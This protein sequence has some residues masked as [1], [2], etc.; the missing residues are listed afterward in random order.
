MSA[1]IGALRGVLSMD[2]A[3]F[4]TGAKRAKATMGTVE[5]RM[6]RMAGQM[7][8]V[9]RRMALGL[10]LPLAGAATVAVRSS[11]QVVDAQAKMARSLDTTVASMQVLERAADLSG[12]SMGEVQQA[13]IQLTK[14]LSQAA[15]GSG[16][17]AK[18]LSRLNLSAAE[19]QN[20][21]LDQRLSAIQSA[22]SEY[23]P[24]AER[25]A[26]ATDLFG[27]RAGLIFTRI[28]GSALKT[29]ADDVA[30]FG[31]AVSDVDAAKIEIANDAISRLGLVGLGVANQ[32]TV[33]LAPAL[34]RISDRAADAATWFNDLSDRTKQFVATGALIAGV[35]GPAAIAFGLVLRVTAPLGVAMAGV[36]STV[37]LAPVRFAAAAKSAIALEVALGATSTKA[38]VASVAIKGLQRG[39]LLLRGAVIATGIGALVVG[40]VHLAVKFGELVRAT[41]GW[42]NA[43]SL[44]GDVAKGVWSGIKTSASSIFPAIQA[45]WKDVQAGFL[46]VLENMSLRWGNFLGSLGAGLDGVV[47]FDGVAQSLKN[48]SGRA[49]EGMAELNAVSSSLAGQAIRLRK[50]AA[51]LASDG[52]DKAKE[53]AGKL[54]K[55]VS[56]TA[57]DSGDASEAVADLVEDLEETE[58]AGVSSSGGLSAVKEEAK[59]LSTELRGPLSSAVDGVARSFGDWVGRGL[60]D[61]RS[62]WDG[63]KDTARRGLSDLATTFARNQIQ[64]GLGFSANGGS[65]AGAS[66]GGVAGGGGFNPLGLAGNLLGGGGT[67]AG[68]ASG[69]GG[70]LSGGGLGASFANIGGLLSGSVGL[71]AGAIGAAIPGLGLILGGAALASRVFGRRFHSSGIRGSFG[72]DGFDGQEFNFFKGGLFRSNKTTYSPVDAGLDQALDAQ[73]DAITSSIHSMADALNLGTGA[74]DSFRGSVF[75][76]QTNGR[77][78]EQIQQDFQDAIE[79]AA[80]DF[81]RLALRTERFSRS[82]EGALDT[83]TRLSSSLT[84]VNGAMELLGSTGFQVSLAGADAASNL[85]DAFG[86]VDQFNSS[87]SGYFSN[88]FSD[89]EREAAELR[90]LEEAFSSLGLAVPESRD[91]FVDL[92]EGVDKTTAGGQKLYAELL[93]LEG[94]LDSVLPEIGAF[95]QEISG[96]VDEVGGEL[97]QRIG[98]SREL[99]N[100]SQA[101]AND[102]QRVS[103]SLRGFVSGLSGTELSAASS[104]QDVAVQRARLSEAFE[105]VRGGDLSA[106]EGLPEIARAYLQTAR[107]MAGSEEEYREIAG[108]VQ[109]QLNF[110]AGVAELEA[111]N[112]EILAGLYE[113]QIDVLT[114]LGQF[115]QLEGLTSDDVALLGEGVQALAEDWDGTVASFESS[116]SGLA[117]AIEE[118]EAFSYEDL[119][120]HLDVAVSLHD[121]APIWLRE[122]VARS[123]S[124]IQTTLDFIIRRDD[125]TAA[126]RWIATRAVSQHVSTLNL[127][128][129]SDID[130]QSRRLA[131][132][133]AEDINRRLMLTLGEDLDPE[134]RALALT[135]FGS[136]FRELNL[137][138]SGESRLAVGLLDEVARLFGGNGRLVFDGGIYLEADRVFSDLSSRASGLV[139]PMD[140]LTVKLS[141]LRDA[142]EADRRSRELQARIASLQERGL[143]AVE[144]ASQGQG[145]VDRFNQLRSEFGIGLVGQNASVTVGRRG[146]ITPSFDYYSG[147]DVVGFKAALR[148][149]FGTD[150]IGSVF[151]GANADTAEARETARSLR[152]QIR[153]LVAIPAFASGGAHRGGTRIVGERGFE[154]ENTGPSR[155]HSHS[156]S[157]S[158]LDNRPIAKSIEE[159]TRFVVSQGQMLKIVIDQIANQIDEWDEG[160]LPGG[161]R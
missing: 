153:S 71:S 119:V 107:A 58:E 13:T 75:E 88:F 94:A 15:G 104:S 155:I 29:A 134:S 151:R 159:L 30:R 74:L 147:G 132:T 117:T 145:V 136:L 34:E 91:A 19:L 118:A 115:L 9:G 122:L 90:L 10:T 63:I 78:E 57:D 5:R 16:A 101:A 152:R 137:R 92:V 26:V 23:V 62:L 143:S 148:A 87:V 33:A 113:T 6:V 146:F 56:E 67:L 93:S 108:R 46:G 54:A 110:A 112:Q 156:E 138:L 68:V 84:S 131:L 66:V 120:G 70:I 96:L 149:S 55:T 35:V 72:Q 51:R 133:R 140:G 160:G 4:D 85:I 38:A 95:T 52:F 80:D 124:G 24:E 59:E 154:I 3:A 161:R 17:A 21:P 12:V 49:F 141:Q 103:D 105:A 150:S 48:S 157:V 32:F 53:A 39:L 36:I 135:R 47:G 45:V 60:Q 83:L 121:Q 142:V 82:G 73:F 11:L 69:L 123:G 106:A 43:L 27:S 7:E 20:I 129:G 65:A 50:E 144:D 114:S 158:M 42:G 81:A 130:P 44:L 31:V 37:A 128:L 79:V 99:V 41:G 127:V 126:D 116:L 102:W 111:G 97:G 14:R 2:S 86:G 109:S 89:A 100:A 8:K 76:V 125:L 18:A 22:L 77:S 40:A 61:F 139:G 98:I 28:D 64:I 1:I 25:A